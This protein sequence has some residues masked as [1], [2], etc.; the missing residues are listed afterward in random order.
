[1]AG[2]LA[3][4]HQDSGVRVWSV[5]KSTASAAG[6]QREFAAAQTPSVCALSICAAACLLAEHE[7]IAVAVGPEPYLCAGFTC[8]A[9]SVAPLVGDL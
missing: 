3:A 1:M 9:G 2:R 4:L 5:L 7:P 8:R 6:E